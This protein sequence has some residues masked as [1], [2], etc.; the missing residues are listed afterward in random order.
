MK[1]LKTFFNQIN[2]KNNIRTFSKGFSTT[3]FIIFL[4]IIGLCLA[5]G[6]PTFDLHRRHE[7]ILNDTESLRQLGIL[8]QKTSIIA[9]HPVILCFSTD[10]QFCS[11]NPTSSKIMAFID[12]NNDRQ[13]SNP[14]QII[15]TLDFSDE[16]I[17]V[18]YKGFPYPEMQVFSANNRINSNG[19]FTVF[20]PK[21]HEAY[22]LSI[23]K[24]GET[25][26][27]HA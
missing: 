16:K 18:S 2:Q 10:Y 21:I 11:T 25:R 9:Q 1:S 17:L 26:V 20:S 6:I 8:A 27:S 7:E 24:A 15:G 12:K 5:I 3:E 19:T 23:N 22:I 4:M 14:D 13:L